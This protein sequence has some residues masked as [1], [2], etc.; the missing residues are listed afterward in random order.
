[1]KYVVALLCLIH[2]FYA[3]EQVNLTDEQGRKQGEWVKYWK[4]SD[5]GSIQ[6]KGQ[7]IDDQPVGQFWHYYPTG[8]VRAIIEHISPSQSFAT[9]YF[10]N[11]EM[12]SEGMY[13]EQKRDSIWI[14]YNNIGQTI[15]LEKYR[16][17]KLE[18]NKILFYLRDQ[19]ER[20]EIKVLSQTLYED[21]IKNGP[22]REFFSSGKIKQ[23]GQYENDKPI[24]KWQRYSAN[25]YMDQSVRYKYGEKHGWAMDY[26]D[27][28]EIVNR[29]LY[30]KGNILSGKEKKAYL[31]MCKKKGIDP[32]D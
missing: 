12:M 31:K 4:G 20:G 29:S 15:S 30:F 32:N 28:G 6:Y 7:F 13:K 17:G 14:N 26:N 27:K 16:D 19:L 22:Y 24:G 1:M 8:E 3:H 25:G 5:N 10:K 21:S 23:T 18:G 11:K 9:Y 2:V